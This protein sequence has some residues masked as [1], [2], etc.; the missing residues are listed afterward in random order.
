MFRG[1]NPVTVDAKGRI[2]IPSAYRQSIQDACGGRMVIA[3]HWDKC[4]LIFPQS[5]FQEFEQALFGRGGLNN[6]VRKIQRL[7]V[8]GARDV[9]MDRQS[10]LLLP[11]KLRE[12][13]D[14]ESHA[15]LMGLGNAFELW[16]EARWQAAND[17]SCEQ[18]AAQAA[19]GELPDVLQDL[20][21]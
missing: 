21:L 10:R 2:S 17:A 19:A 20:P 15:V 11:P 6:Q 5:K 18:L 8:G 4:L 16:S 7:F 1:S 3:P 13:S 12:F 9:E 14:I